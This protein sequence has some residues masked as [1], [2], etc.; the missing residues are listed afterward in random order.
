MTESEIIKLLE[1]AE[2]GD[3]WECPFGINGK[4]TDDGYVC[5]AEHP[6][7][8]MASPNMGCIAHQAAK[9]F[10]WHTAP[11]S[12]PGWYLL[13]LRR[14]GEITYSAN[15]WADILGFK[16][17]YAMQGEIIGWRRIED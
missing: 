12:A 3:P 8:D 15:K 10:E 11:V 6:D 5:Y 1:N 14:N 9:L 4:L 7:G 13:K 2:C 17:F 16:W